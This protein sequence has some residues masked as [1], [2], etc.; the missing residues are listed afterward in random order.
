MGY[1]WLKALIGFALAAVS[2]AGWAI[3][4]VNPFGVNVRQSGPTSIFLT[5]QNLLPGQQSVESFW[6]AQLNPVDLAALNGGQRVFSSNPC[7]P[8]TFLGRLPDRFDLSQQSGVSASN[9]TD[10]MT[11]PTSVTRRK[12]QEIETNPGGDPRFFYVRRFENPS[13][14][15]VVTCRMAG[16]GARVP[17]AL[18]DVRLEFQDDDANYRPVTVIGRG[19]VV[20]RFGATIRYNGTGRLVGRWEVMIPGDEEPTAED[21][22]TEASLPVE[23]RG[24]QRRY[25][26]IERF[27]KYVPPTGEVYLAGPD[28][29]KIPTD[30][31]GNYKILLRVEASEER[32]ARS[33]AVDGV[34]LSGGVAGFPMPVLRYHVGTPESVS[35]I[36]AAVADGRLILTQPADSSSIGAGT[37]LSFGWVE[38]SGSALY[39]LEITDG[40]QEL[41]SAV[42]LPGV[43]G[44]T[45]PPWLSEPGRELRWRVTALSSSGGMVSRSG[46]RSLRI[47]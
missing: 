3:T 20:P 13:E 12:R 24:L 36:E 5:F 47:E 30:I 37:P 29:A 6:C 10:V 41:L 4:D 23:Q 17:L 34:V 31:D 9:V 43:G 19:G 32:E 27:D 15:V 39:R 21:L 2:Q 33:N 18:L 28:P 44:Y 26:L 14:F 42:V 45:P 16:G 46:W 11:I 35:T 25:T 1:K 38:V 40:D 8:G 7:E 22:L